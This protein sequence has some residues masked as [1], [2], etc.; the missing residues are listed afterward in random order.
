MQGVRTSSKKIFHCHSSNCLYFCAV[1]TILHLICITAVL[2][3]STFGTWTWLSYEWNKSEITRLFCINKDKPTMHCNGSCH[4][5]KELEK[6]ESTP[7]NAKSAS[8]KTEVLIY[9][10][11]QPVEL[12]TNQAWEWQPK[13]TSF[14]RIQP[15]LLGFLKP[16]F[17]PPGLTVVS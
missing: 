14:T 5:K 7:K 1:R 11:P 4:L 9:D 10:L 16:H 3:Q 2:A 13:P 8:F 15:T 12:F 6:T 17:H